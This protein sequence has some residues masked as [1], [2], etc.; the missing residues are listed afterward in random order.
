MQA[1]TVTHHNHFSPFHEAK[2]RTNSFLLFRYSETWGHNKLSAKMV[3]LFYLE[4]CK[5]YASARYELTPESKRCIQPKTTQFLA[6]TF[7]LLI[8]KPKNKNKM[9]LNYAL[10]QKLKSNLYILYTLPS[11]FVFFVR[12]TLRITFV[13]R[14]RGHEEGMLFS[15]NFL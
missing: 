9:H 10:I 6:K 1:R 14:T 8:Y 2:R 15:G 5:R 12:G 13:Y 3:D 11:R 7:Q 4:C